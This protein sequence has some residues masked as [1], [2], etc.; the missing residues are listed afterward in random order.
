M[1]A[2]EKWA[3][4]CDET[5]EKYYV[6]PVGSA[7]RRVAKDAFRAGLRRAADIANAVGQIGQMSA[8]GTA[9]VDYMAKK[10]SMAIL[11]EIG[12]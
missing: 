10:I 11:K 2:F 7:G 3:D 4:D 5:D 12:E 8:E 1:D 6:C 9:Q